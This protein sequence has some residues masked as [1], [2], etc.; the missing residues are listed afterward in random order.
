MT[1]H[2]AGIPVRRVNPPRIR[3]VH[4]GPTFW[5]NASRAKLVTAPPRPPPANTMPFARPLLRLKYCAGVTDTVMK[6]R[7]IP[8]PNMTPLVQNKPATLLT[9]K[10]L[11]ISAALRKH[12]PIVPV[13]CAPMAR[14]TRALIIAMNDIKAIAM[15]PM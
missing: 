1:S 6:Q 11:R 9:E 10:L 5:I 8:K 14:T 12:T 15:D 2:A 7:L 3:Y 4:S 13:F